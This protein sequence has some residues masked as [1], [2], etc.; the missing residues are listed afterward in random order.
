MQRR[1]PV[2]ASTWQ[3]RPGPQPL[4]PTV[5]KHAVSPLRPTWQTWP[6]G[7]PAL[8]SSE[9]APSSSLQLAP[10]KARPIQASVPAT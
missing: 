10:V 8:S 3:S 6:S 4:S 2:A 1:S 7:Q 9:Q 5:Q